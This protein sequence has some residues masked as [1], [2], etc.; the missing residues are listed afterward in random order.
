MS[1]KE[2]NQSTSRTLKVLLLVCAGALLVIVM[3]LASAAWDAT[4][5]VHATKQAT[6]ACGIPA[7]VSVFLP[8]NCPAQTQN[9]LR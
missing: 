3:T 7:R 5:V 1:E 6:D 4:Q 2:T 8:A 9:A